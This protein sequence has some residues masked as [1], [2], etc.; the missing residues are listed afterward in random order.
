MHGQLF[1]TDFLLRGVQET[2]AWKSIS[3]AALDIFITQIKA[4]YAP[5]SADSSLNEGQTEDELIEPV[6]DLLGW[7][8]AWTSQINLSQSGREDVPDFLLF[9]DSPAKSRAM[10]EKSDDNRARHGVALLEAKRWLRQLDRSAEVAALSYTAHDLAPFARDLGHVNPDGSVKPPFAWAPKDR[11]H[12]MARLDALF[13]HLYVLSTFPIVGE[14]D[15][16]AH[17]TY[18][19]R[20]LILAYLARIRSGTLSHERLV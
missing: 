2:E 18:R 4:H 12:R 16:K 3:N 14:Q 20:D 17:G 13:F 19:T 9:A 5:Y 15:M 6:I 11:A 1:S 8:D 10:A 7:D